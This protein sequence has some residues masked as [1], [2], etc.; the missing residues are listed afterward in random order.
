MTERLRPLYDVLSPRNVGNEKLHSLLRDLQTMHLDAKGPV[1]AETQKRNQ[2]FWKAEKYRTKNPDVWNREKG[3]DESEQSKEYKKHAASIRA[4]EDY[5]QTAEGK[6][7]R[8]RAMEAANRREYNAIQKYPK[9]ARQR[10]MYE[11][12][13]PPAD[14]DW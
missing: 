11:P 4:Y 12:A 14:D 8:E 9:E 10:G 6:A 7:K 2:N 13:P 5:Q 1:D 3:L